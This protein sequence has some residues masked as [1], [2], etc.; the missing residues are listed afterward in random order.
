M[1]PENESNAKLRVAMIKS[2]STPE[3]MREEIKEDNGKEKNRLENIALTYME[4]AEIPRQMKL[5]KEKIISGKGMQLKITTAK[6]QELCPTGTNII[7]PDDLEEIAKVIVEIINTT[8]HNASQK[9]GGAGSERILEICPPKF[10]N[11]SAE[12]Q[13]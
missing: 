9:M 6:V 13:I 11:G 1:D 4:K 3:R 10:P 7:P 8:G 2:I 12:E 5:V